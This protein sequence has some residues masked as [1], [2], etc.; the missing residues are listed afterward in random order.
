MATC[1]GIGYG[2]MTLI[3]DELGTP[4]NLIQQEGKDITV[5]KND[6]FSIDPSIKL[7]MSFPLLSLNMRAGYAFDISGKYWRL[8]GK[9][10]EFTKTSFASPYIQVGASLNIKTY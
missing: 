10:K 6:V 5:Y 4:D 9:A 8:D 2:Q 3:E 7:R 1:L